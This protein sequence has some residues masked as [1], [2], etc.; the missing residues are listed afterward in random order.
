MDLDSNKIIGYLTPHKGY[1]VKS[2]TI[3][4]SV[5]NTFKLTTKDVNIL[6]IGDKLTTHE[7][8][9]SGSQ[10]GDKITDDFDPASNKIYNSYRRI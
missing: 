3:I 7:T 8:L 5:N 6:R 2:L 1:V 4:D 9:A 10:W